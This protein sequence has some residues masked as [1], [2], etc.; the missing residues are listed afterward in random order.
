MPYAFGELNFRIAAARFRGSEFVELG[1]AQQNVSSE[2]WTSRFSS[3]QI[4]LA[5]C[6]FRIRGL[7]GLGLSVK[8][9]WG[10]GL[11]GLKVSGLGVT[12]YDSM[13]W[14]MPRKRVHYL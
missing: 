4:H 1:T 6:R 3:R 5:A 7:Q 13:A 9:A 11:K 14:H 2:P 12:V 10:L 8:R